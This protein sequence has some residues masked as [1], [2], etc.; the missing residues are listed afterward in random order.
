MIAHR[1]LSTGLIACVAAMALAQQ[2]AKPPAGSQLTPAEQAAG[3]KVLFDGKDTTAW[4]GYKQKSFPTEGW[5]VADGCLKTVA[6]ATGGDLITADQYGDF[7]LTLEWKVAPKG[8]S[9]IIYRVTEAN[10]ETWQTGPEYQILDDAGAG[11]AP[12]SN[13]S[14][15]SMFDLC[16]AVAGK[17][18]KPAGEFNQVRIRVQDGVV[19]HWLN[20]KKVV[21]C[22]LV[23][24]EWKKLI[25]GSKFREYDGFGLQPRGHIAL[26]HHGDEVWFRNIRVRD[27][28]A[29]L[30][31]EVRLFNGKDLTGWQACLPEGGKM[32]EVWTVADGVL[33]CKGQ[34]VGYIRTTADYTNYVLKLEWRFNPVTKQA[35]NSG[36]LLRLIGPDKVWPK[37]VEAQL[38]SGNAGDFWNIDEFPMKV[39]PAR[40]EGRNTKKTHG[41]ERPIGDWNEYEITVDHGTITLRVN[42]EV[43]NEAT[44]VQETPGKIGLQSEGAEIHFRNVRLAPLP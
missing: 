20:G 16:P 35:G 41:A 34:P 15:G 14:A 7:E 40:T 25:A 39:D 28:A 42:G 3:W 22:R 11:E 21:E 43:L 12:E 44:D 37:S 29:P 4:R 23:G 33:V 30:P 32:D 27:L 8:N 18:L 36:V 38:Q 6:G 10:D 17:V 13:H 5:V 2:P 9:G 31:G 24:D 26:Q 1:F 19:Q